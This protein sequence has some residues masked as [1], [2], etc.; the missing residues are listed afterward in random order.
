MSKERVNRCFFFLT[1][2][3]LN[4]WTGKVKDFSMKSHFCFIK[5]ITPL[6]SA[7]KPETVMW[8]GEMGSHLNKYQIK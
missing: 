6:T 7:E 2:T 4:S 8:P 3:D 5:S 1:K